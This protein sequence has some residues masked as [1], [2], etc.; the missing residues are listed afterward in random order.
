MTQKFNKSKQCGRQTGL[1]DLIENVL[2]HLGLS[3]FSH[4]FAIVVQLLETLQTNWQSDKSEITCVD[5]L[6]LT[7]LPL[8]GFIVDYNNTLYCVFK[9]LVERHFLAQ[10]QLK[11]NKPQLGQHGILW[12][13]IRKVHNFLFFAFPS[14]WNGGPTLYCH[15][16]RILISIL[17][18]TSTNNI[19]LPIY[20][21]QHPKAK[22][23]ISLCLSIVW[24]NISS[25]YESYYHRWTFWDK[26]YA[27]F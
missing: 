19:I 9:I 16:C 27:H 22:K 25:L 11:L 6:Q 4:I 7:Q 18:S 10:I 5:S 24:N 14:L 23:T 12:S 2:Q 1:L 8:S 13:Q 17:Y 15:I 3:H 21:K 20:F 26:S